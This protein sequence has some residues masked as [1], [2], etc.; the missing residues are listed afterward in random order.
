MEKT[1]TIELTNK[2]LKLLMR[3]LK[4]CEDDRSSMSCND[5]YSSEEK[6]FSKKERM[7]MQR[8]MFGEDLSEDEIDGYLF[9]SQYVEYL[10]NIINKQVK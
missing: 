9:N 5:P 7:Q 1:N 2:Q 6:L 4:D 8:E 10:I 3:V